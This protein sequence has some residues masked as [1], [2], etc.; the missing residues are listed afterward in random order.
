MRGKLARENINVRC[1][2][3]DGKKCTFE[4][5]LGIYVLVRKENVYG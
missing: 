1:I 4:F 2:K 5:T 3:R